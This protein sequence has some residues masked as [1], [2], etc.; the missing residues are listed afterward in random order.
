MWFLDLA[1]IISSWNSTRSISV[2]LE[3]RCST[4]LTALQLFEDAKELSDEKLQI[5]VHRVMNS[6]V[7][8][9][10]N[11]LLAVV[12]ACMHVIDNSKE[13]T[14]MYAHYLLITIIPERKGYCLSGI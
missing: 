2:V 4:S 11:S 12:N 10:M 1:L 9:Y 13:T 14:Y 7:P 3:W 8:Y 6:A 5:Y